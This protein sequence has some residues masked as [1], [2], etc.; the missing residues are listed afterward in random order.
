MSKFSNGETKKLL[1]CTFC[2]K[3]N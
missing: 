1:V 3:S 2:G